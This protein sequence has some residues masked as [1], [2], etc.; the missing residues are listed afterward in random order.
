MENT[1]DF[2]YRELLSPEERV[3]WQ[4]LWEKIAPNDRTGAKRRGLQVGA[5]DPGVRDYVMCY[6]VYDGKNLRAVV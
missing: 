1:K 2:M 3:I 6:D 4:A 5:I